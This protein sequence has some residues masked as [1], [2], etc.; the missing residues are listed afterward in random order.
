MSPRRKSPESA[1]VEPK[2]QQESAEKS[3]ALS[4]QD[5]EMLQAAKDFYQ[6]LSE[7]YG[8]IVEPEKLAQ[9]NSVKDKE[10]Y[11]QARVE[12]IILH[13]EYNFYNSL[14]SLQS[15]Q[16]SLVPLSEEQVKSLLQ[17][18]N[19]TEAINSLTGMKWALTMHKRDLDSGVVRA[20]AEDLDLEDFS[21]KAALKKGEDLHDM[22]NLISDY[23]KQNPSL[24]ST[25]E[26]GWIN[27]LEDTAAQ[28]QVASI[29]AQ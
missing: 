28:L 16:S 29:E 6:S 4:A 9:L 11:R 2:K 17:G 23:L 8:I 13:L 12:R 14:D 24:L 3:S 7:D 18:K 19:M 27:S 15:P 1:P 25:L 20:L 26:P 10:S 22:L 5:Q 21:Q